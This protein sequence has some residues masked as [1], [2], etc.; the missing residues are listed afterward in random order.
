MSIE[1]TKTK[2]NEAVE[3]PT[4][5][6]VTTAGVDIDFD[7]KDDRTVLIFTS[8]ASS[9]I[10]LTVANGDGLQACGDEEFKINAG[11][12]VVVVLE[13]MKFKKLTDGTV[14]VKASGSGVTVQVVEV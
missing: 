11:K 4:A 2:L 9:Q 6:S 12:T 13:S 10:T 7:G 3:L 8:S 1:I 14:N 5:T